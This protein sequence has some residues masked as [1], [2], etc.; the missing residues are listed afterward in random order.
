[1]V[2]STFY[3]IFGLALLSMAF[4]LMIEEL[5]AKVKWLGKKLGARVQRE[6]SQDIVAGIIDDKTL[7][8]EASS[9]KELTEAL[10]ATAADENKPIVPQEATA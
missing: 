6:R 1:M 7:G 3:I 10:A 4:N 5:I 2:G 8:P 9:D